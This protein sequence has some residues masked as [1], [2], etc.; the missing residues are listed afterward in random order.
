MLSEKSLAID[1]LEAGGDECPKKPVV[2]VVD[3]N[4]QNLLALEAILSRDDR[5][6]ITAGSGEE[7]LR[8]L[9]DHEA[10]VVLLDV[11]MLGMDGYETAALIRNREKTRDVPI[12]FV[13]SYNKEDADV[14]KGYAHGGV[15]YIFKP[16]VPDILYSKVNVFVELYKRTEDLKRKNEELER[17]EKELVRTKAAASLIKHAP[18]PVF[19]SDVHGKIL[20]ANDAVSELLGLQS[21]DV[22]DQSLAVFL[23][24]EDM[25]RFADA[26]RETVE[27]GVVRNVRLNPKNSVGHITPTMLN[28][29]ALRDHDGRV[30]GAIG[31]LR[32]MT[33]HDS[34]VR[35]L[36]QSRASLVE[37]IRELERFEQAVIG[38]E[39][40]MIAMEKEI[41]RLKAQG[42]D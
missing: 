15:D 26:L 24:P 35:D 7:A 37:K 33:A 39:L 25:R 9:L 32:D 36:E 1:S 29:S 5:T 11:Q 22:V 42:Q 40:K 28:A 41:A 20:Q 19:L 8:Y 21:K 12:I 23:P 4:A 14:V 2:L 18:D 27:Q 13:T 38:R 6:V 34:M 30:V 3:D 16:V 10:A 31:I 17:T